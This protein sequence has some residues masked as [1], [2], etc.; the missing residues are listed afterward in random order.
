MTATQGR[1]D[2]KKYRAMAEE[3]REIADGVRDEASAE[4]LRNVAGDYDFLAAS[5][6]KIEESE[7]FLK[8][9]K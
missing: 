5:A 8:D 7:R 9:L 6:E 2:A 1:F 3:I 4:C